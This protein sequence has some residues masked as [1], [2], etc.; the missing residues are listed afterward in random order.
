MNDIW[1][2]S[3][4]EL[5]ELLTIFREQKVSYYQIAIF[6]GIFGIFMPLS[7]KEMW[8][9]SFAPVAFI[10]FIPIMLANSV[11][12]DSFAG[13]RE[14]QTLET[15]L[16]T[17]LPD[18]AILLGKIL[19]ALIYALAFTILILVTSLLTLNLAKGTPGLFIYSPLL[20]LIS[21][22]GSAL[23]SL[24][25]ITLGISV[26][27]RAKSVRAAAQVL[28][29]PIILFFLLLGF[30]LPALIKTL[31]ANLLQEMSQYLSLIDPLLLAAVPLLLLALVD[32]ILLA[33]VVRRFHRGRFPRHKIVSF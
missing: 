12:A 26:S 5:H 9:T 28:N 8:M 24:L 10:I 7:Q 31:P 4:K 11:V 23:T 6:V 30:G 29:L 21:L 27:L 25:A 22:V 20:L 16:A 19:A 14:R 2:V 15:L 1:I 17:R 18:R 13:E 33:L 32:S 3:K